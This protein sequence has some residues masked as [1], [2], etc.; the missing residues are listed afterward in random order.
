M[1]SN[2]LNKVEI[3]GYVGNSP[4]YRTTKQNE[5]VAKFVVGTEDFLFNDIK[6][7]WH[8]V[9][10]T[11]RAALHIVKEEIDK[12]TRVN[13]VGSLY[14]YKDTSHFMTRH[15]SEIVITD[16]GSISVITAENSQLATMYYD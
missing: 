1:M 16:L 14:T 13:I 8:T 11:D 5:E 12:G 2:T 15:I 10:V 4:E 9:I 3:Q 7:Q 6:K